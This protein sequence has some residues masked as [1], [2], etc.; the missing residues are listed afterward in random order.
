MAYG[1]QTHQAPRGDYISLSLRIAKGV[2]SLVTKGVNSRL[3]WNIRQTGKLPFGVYHQV[4][5]PCDEPQTSTSSGNTDPSGDADQVRLLT[6][7]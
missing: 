2:V 7:L 3:P 5:A 1:R 6:G 4:V